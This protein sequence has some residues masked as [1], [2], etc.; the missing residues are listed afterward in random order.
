MAA[1]ARSFETLTLDA[2]DSVELVLHRNY[3]QFTHGPL[4]R[5]PVPHHGRQRARYDNVKLE[6]AIPIQLQVG[7][8]TSR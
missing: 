4:S 6:A 8:C 3:F 1:I 7:L 2:Q 5:L